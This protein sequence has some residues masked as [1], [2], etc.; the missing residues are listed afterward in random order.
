MEAL[1]YLG[2]KNNPLPSMIIHDLNTGKMNAHTFLKTIRSDKRLKNIPV[3]IVTTSSK[4]HDFVSCFEFDHVIG[5]FVK[6][7]DY[8]D[9]IKSIAS[10]GYIEK[11]K[12]SAKGI[13]RS[14]THSFGFL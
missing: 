12:K 2:T 10:E 6:P 8:F 3:V 7:V 5:Y 13:F 11:K 1:D 4:H 9:L 14:T